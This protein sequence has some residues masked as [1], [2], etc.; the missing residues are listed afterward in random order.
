MIVT[1][2]PL[3]EDVLGSYRDACGRDLPGY[4]GHVYRTFNLARRLLP[5]SAHAE[6]LAA[7]AAFHDIGIWA[8]GTFDYLEPSSQR[9]AEYVREHLPQLD[10]AAIGH[11]IRLHHKLTSC[12]QQGG[13][14]AEAFRR[15]DLIDLTFGIV[16]FG[17][18]R[19]F[20]TELRAAFPNAGFH[21]CLFR[22]AARWA[23]RH[24]ARP[25][26]MLSW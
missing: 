25:L 10:G 7:V 12:L 20:V 2:D 4:R 8:D 11:T 15:A 1:T 17:L 24:P 26:P 19:S 13:A 21:R 18:P 14:G 9:A 23:L 16:R 3:I 6:A 22:V 5:G